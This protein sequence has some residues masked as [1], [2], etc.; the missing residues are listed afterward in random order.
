MSALDPTVV[1]WTLISESLLHRNAWRAFFLAD[2]TSYPDSTIL[3]MAIGWS[4]PDFLSVYF[5][6][7]ETGGVNPSQLPISPPTE[8]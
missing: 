3:E 7:P 1:L 4:G 5:S 8:L 6:E 2:Q